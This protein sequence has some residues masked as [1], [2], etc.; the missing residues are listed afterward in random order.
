MF[1][2]R[3]MVDSIV[4]ME[5]A[6]GRGPEKGKSVFSQ[7]ALKAITRAQNRAPL[8]DTLALHGRQHR[9]VPGKSTFG[10]LPVWRSNG[11]GS[12][13]CERAHKVMGEVVH[14]NMST[15]L[16]ILVML[17]VLCMH[18]HHIRETLGTGYGQPKHLYDW[19]L[20]ERADALA[21][22]LQG[23][24]RY[25]MKVLLADNGEDIGVAGL[26]DFRRPEVKKAEESMAKAA[27]HYIHQAATKLAARRARRAANEARYRAARKQAKMPLLTGHPT[28]SVAAAQPMLP[29][30]ASTVKRCGNGIDFAPLSLHW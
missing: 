8:F 30:S 13:A 24:H 7:G 29:L 22:A 5:R 23:E 2:S 28:A 3:G 11:R 12:I 14:P 27:A 16:G 10:V 4:G 18:N 6:E 19:W 15:L 20:A 25:V 21:Y 1:E 9:P 17:E 26:K